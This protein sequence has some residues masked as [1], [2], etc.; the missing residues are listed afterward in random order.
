MNK[1]IFLD[2]DGTLNNDV[3]HYYVHRVSDLKLNN[4]VIDNLKRLYNKGFKLIV[5]SN[6]AGIAK[7]EYQ[8]T[9]TDRF[10]EELNRLLLENGCSIEEF[11]YCPHHDKVSACLCRKPLPLLIEKAC[12]RFDIDKTQSYM[13]GDSKRDAEAAESAG[14]TAFIIDKNADMKEVVNKIL[15]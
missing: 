1:A 5:I 4:G 12:A 3:G 11:Y 15:S 7:Q 2:R 14:I 10:H 8:K 6:Q 13:I 9:D